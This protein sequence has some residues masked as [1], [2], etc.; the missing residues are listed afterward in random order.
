MTQRTHGLFPVGYALLDGLHLVQVHDVDEHPL[1]VKDKA[2]PPNATVRHVA[3]DDASFLQS[4]DDLSVDLVRLT[5][6][7][8]MGDL[9]TLGRYY[10]WPVDAVAALQPFSA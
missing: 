10:G 3:L 4:L 7:A 5:T 2:D 6:V 1:A 8:D 9:A